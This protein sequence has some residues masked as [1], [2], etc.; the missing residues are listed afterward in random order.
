MKQLPVE[1]E[2]ANA[3]AEIEP[4]IAMGEQMLA[5]GEIER[6]L[7]VFGQ[8]DDMVPNHP[9]VLS[10]TVRALVAANRIEEAEAAIAA[11]PEDLAK[12][13]E[14]ERAK[15]ALALARDAKPVDDLAGAGG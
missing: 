1:S 10:G 12:L 15:S 11:L 5:E 8:I 14:I 6:A 2:A 7:S 3:E 4:L 9:A 13:P